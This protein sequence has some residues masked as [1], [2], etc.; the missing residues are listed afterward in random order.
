MNCSGYFIDKNNNKYFTGIVESGSNNNG[1]YI[2]FADG[3]MICTQRVQKNAPITKKQ[4]LVYTSDTI[5]LPDFPMQF[6]SIPT[7]VKTLEKNEGQWFCWLTAKGMSSKTNPGTVLIGRD[8]STGSG[9][10]TV[11]ITVI[12]IG[13]WK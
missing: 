13:R 5:E 9:I 7:V 8:S 10:A 11:Y 6:T 12:A 2:K 1:N 3:T 4:T